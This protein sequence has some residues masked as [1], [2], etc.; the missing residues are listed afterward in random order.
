MM[1]K[2]ATMLMMLMMIFTFSMTANAEISPSGKPV[3]E[4]GTTTGT[5]PKTGEN[6]VVLYSLGAAVV[7]LASGAVVVRKKVAA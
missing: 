2:L 1:K 5:S 3:T 6:D 4:S 7:V